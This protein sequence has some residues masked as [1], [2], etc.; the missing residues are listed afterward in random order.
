M[1]KRTKYIILGCAGAGILLAGFIAARGSGGS[2]AVKIEPVTARDLVASVTA[3]GQI[4]PQRK[5]DISADITGR[6]TR[7]LVKE[8]DTVSRGQLLLEIDPSQYT[9]DVERASA[10]VS[11]SRAQAAQARASL[12]QARANYERIAELRDRNPKLVSADQIE[13]LRT[14]LEVQRAMLENSEYAVEQAEA[15]LRNARS[16]LN[17]ATIVAPMSGRITRL[18]VELGETAIMGTLNK[19]AA[20]LLTIADMSAMETKVKVGETDISHIQPGDS[21]VV[22]IDAFP[23]STFR[24]VV[25]NVS[26]SSVKAGAGGVSTDQSVDYEVTVQLF[27]VPPNA[28]PDFTTQAKII[29]ATRRQ[30]I[31]IPNIALTVRENTP[32]ASKDSPAPFGQ[33]SSS[34]KPGERDVEGVFI[35][36]AANKVTFRPVRVGV[37][38]DGYFEVVNGLRVGERIV[39]GPYQAIRELKDGTTIRAA[40][41]KDQSSEKSR[42]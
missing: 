40:V 28:R 16:A 38:G 30:V 10:S 37:S 1:K 11:G 23:D 7:L 8:G 31:A 2:V 24:G 20:T 3:S 34:G 35:I 5:V 22:Q 41:T 4:Q 25:T 26:N 36:D 21:A 27:Q 9:A 17:K 6:I 15:G 29:T 32:V 14:E 12:K 19:D 18:N 13:K 39:A 33:T 42:K